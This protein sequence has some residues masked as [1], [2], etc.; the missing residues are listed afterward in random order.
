MSAQ[1]T[2]RG[3]RWIATVAA[4][5][6]LAVGG[7]GTAAWA[8]E[9]TTI[10]ENKYGSVSIHKYAL[11]EAGFGAEG[12]GKEL[13][14]SALTGLEPLAG[15]TFTLQRLT[16]Y[17][18]T[19][20]AGWTGL[21]DLSLQD[22]IDTAEK[23]TSATVTTDANGLAVAGNL[24]LGAY[25]VTET[26]A[27]SGVIAT[28]PFV[29][30]VPTTDPDNRNSW[31]YDVHVYP[32]NQVAKAEKSAVDTDATVIGDEVV[33]KILGDIPMTET[34][35]G[36]K[37]VDE[38]DPR[39]G[40][41]TSNPAVLS[42]VGT[43]TALVA[44]DYKI[45]ATQAAGMWT[46]TAEFTAQ[47][48]AKLAAVK[49]VDTDARVQLLIPTTVLSIGDGNIENTALVFP[50]G[51]S[52]TI[53]PGQP[54]GPMEPG[55]ST[56]WGKIAI[57][58]HEQGDKAAVLAGAKFQVFRSEGDARAR[59]NALKINDKDTWE[60]AADGTVTIEGLR[61]SAW[62]NGAA[63]KPGET[64]YQSYWIA[65]V[66]APDGYALLSAPIEVTVGDP[67]TQAVVAVPNALDNGGF[68]LP[69]TGGVFNSALLYGAGTIILAGVVLLVIRRRKVAADN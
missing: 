32:K 21:Q 25:L 57:L 49:A 42:L 12:N 68:E 40:Y 41:S 30:T 55:G 27:P 56:K 10:D 65:E 33:W 52:F 28:K 9:P 18:L 35:D 66:E 34:I 69:F 26:S 67:L 43:S 64:G 38:L 51:P 2:K 45:N 54:G 15:V 19:I 63:V 17:D 29:V 46:V 24:P 61:Q 39:L 53:T 22:A 36:Y 58:K 4:A 60:T 8:A 23:V 3:V 7:A 20:N 6:V 13:D 50:N 48:L 62:A 47:G 1:P 11:P 44:G 37:I 59:T 14:P 5:G 31:M 16:E